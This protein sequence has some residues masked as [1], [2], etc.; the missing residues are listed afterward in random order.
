MASRFEVSAAEVRDELL[1]EGYIEFQKV[2]RKSET[3]K[4]NYFYVLTDKQYSYTE[5]PKVQNLLSIANHEQV[6]TV[7]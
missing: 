6:K 1:A 5:E 7:Q 2:T 4:N 3:Q